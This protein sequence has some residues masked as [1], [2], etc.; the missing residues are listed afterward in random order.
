MSWLKPRSIRGQLISGLVLLEG[1]LVIT[2]ATL[3]VREQALEI[4]ERARLRLESE[5]SLLALQSQESLAQGQGG[6]PG[7]DTARHDQLPQYPCSDGYRRQR[8]DHCQQRPEDERQERADA[9]G[10]EVPDG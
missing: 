1:L 3:L 6:I 2:F 9:P 8:P 5:V 7:A 4:H 10:K